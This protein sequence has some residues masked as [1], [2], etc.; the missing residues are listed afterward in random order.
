VHLVQRV[1]PP[2]E[3]GLPPEAAD[4]ERAVRQLDDRV[5]ATIADLLRE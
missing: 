2:I 3:P 4:D 5:R 1:A